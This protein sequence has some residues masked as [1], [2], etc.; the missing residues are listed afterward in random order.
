MILTKYSCRKLKDSEVEAL[1]RIRKLL[2]VTQAELA[3]R[4][5]IDVTYLSKIENGKVESL[6]EKLWDRLWSILYSV[7]K[8]R[9]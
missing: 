6:P 4:A 7:E 9:A 2:G 1:P 3:K 5:S 8:K